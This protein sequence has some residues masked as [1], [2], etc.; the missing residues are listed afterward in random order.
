MTTVHGKRS[1]RAPE[2]ALW[3]QTAQ[4]LL[5]LGTARRR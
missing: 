4:T 5:L 3:K 1:N 2:A